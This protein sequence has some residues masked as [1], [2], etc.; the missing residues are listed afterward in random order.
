MSENPLL[1]F[2]K[3]QATV[4]A[5]LTDKEVI[6]IRHDLAEFT[7][8]QFSKVASELHKTESDAEQERVNEAV[9]L[10]LEIGSSLISGANTLFS[11]GNTYAAAALVRQ[12]VEVEYL[13]WA[14]ED[15][16]KEAEK[17][18]VSDK[19]ERMKFFTPA[20]LRKAAQGRFRSK[21][22]GYHCELGGHPVPGANVLLENA[23]LQAQLLLSDMLGHAGRIWDHLVSWADGE[24]KQNVVLAHKEKML[25]RYIAWKQADITTRMPPPP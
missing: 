9:A 21:D 18:I 1:S 20:K 16:K 19:E 13:A 22:Y 8:V 12:L 15:D 2:L 7:S 6:A 14:F 10:I 5:S 4:N 17:W 24:K 11:L 25:E 3:F 23:E